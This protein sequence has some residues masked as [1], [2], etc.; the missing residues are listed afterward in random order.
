MVSPQSVKR[1]IQSKPKTVESV[2]LVNVKKTPIV[3]KSKQNGPLIAN[4]AP[5]TLQVDMISRNTTLTPSVYAEGDG[6]LNVST[7]V[8]EELGGAPVPLP[9]RR[10]AQSND[11]RA[12]HMAPQMTRPLNQVMNSTIN[13]GF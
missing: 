7:V 13:R 9:P 8:S 3:V 5:L 4:N 1:S 12:N 11:D 10:Q 6:P 2:N